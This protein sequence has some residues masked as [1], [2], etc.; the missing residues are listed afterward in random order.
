MNSVISVY[1]HNFYHLLLN[2]HSTQNNHMYLFPFLVF[3]TKILPKKAIKFWRFSLTPMLWTWGFCIDNRIHIC[4]FFCTSPPGAWCWWELSSNQDSIKGPYYSGLFVLTM[5]SWTY[6][7][8]RWSSKL[9]RV[10]HPCLSLLGPLVVLLWLQL[11]C[12]TLCIYSFIP[13]SMFLRLYMQLFSFILIYFR[14]LTQF[15]F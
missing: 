5:R 14:W 2:L 1:E 13:A 6:N 11:F 10:S 4:G 9:S 7:S 3:V 8:L 15:F 12:T